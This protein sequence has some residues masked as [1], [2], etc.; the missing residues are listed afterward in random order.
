M[1]VT[2]VIL[3]LLWG[4]VYLLMAEGLNLI[5]GVMK[6]VNLAHGDFIVLGGLI[7]FSLF[8]ATAVSPVIS[9]PIAALLLAALGAAVQFGVVERI[10]LGRPDAE[11]RTLLATFGLSYVVAN[12]SFLIWGSQFQSIPFLQGF[13]QMGKIAL[14]QALLA[15]SAL[16]FVFAVLFHLWLTR[17]MLGKSIRAVA[18]SG[19]GAAACGLDIVSLR[20]LAF[21]LGSAMAGGAG[22]L[23]IAL[24]PFQTASGGDL[25]RAGLHADRARR[26]RQLC[27][28]L[29]RRR[30]PGP[31]RGRDPICLRLQCGER[32]D[33]CRLHRRAGAAPA[34]PA[35]Q[36][37]ARMKQRNVEIV[38]FL[39]LLAAGACVAA[40]G[41]GYQA[42]TLF[43]MLMMT[44]LAIGWNIISGFTGYVSFGQVAFFGLGAYVTAVLILQGDLPWPLA[45]AISVVG[46]VI[47][48]LPLGLVMLRLS[49]IF[50][51]LGMFGL[52]R[53]FQL[54]ASSLDITGGPMG[55]T[56]PAAE[57]PNFLAAVALGVV[58]L[59][60]TLSFILLR[61]KLGLRL[62]ATRDDPV[63]AQAAGVD[64]WA[65]KV[66]AFCLSAAIA[67]IAGALYVWNVGYLDPSS[68]FAGTIE[69][70]TVLMVLAGGIGT[71]WGPVLGGVLI[72]LLSTFLWARFP[73]EQQIILGLLTML[74]AMFAPGGLM[75]LVMQRG[76]FRRQ[77]IWPPMP[78]QGAI[79]SGARRDAAPVKAIEPVLSGAKV[80]IHY[81]G[82]KAVD[83][84][85]VQ[86]K[87]GEMLAIIGPNGAGKSSLFNL[88]SGFGRPTHGDVRFGG[89]S[90]IGAAPYRLARNGV[91]RTFQTSRLFRSL[92]VW[93][94]VLVA[95]TSVAVDRAS[96]VAATMLIL[97]RVGLLRNWKDLPD[98][99]PPGRQ[100]L[101]EIA[102]SLALAPKVLLLD[103]A[104][105]G[106]TPQEIEQV[107]VT[108][109]AALAAGVAIIAIEHV[110]PAIAPL[111]ARV[112]VLDFGRTIAEGEPRSVLRDP[113]V[114]EAYMGL[115]H[116]A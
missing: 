95:A 57:S 39:L 113:V 14:P 85:D 36:V 33:L 114:V 74:V 107:H 47:V 102:R 101:L 12:A 52:A 92:T 19:L 40:F 65:A 98:L 21:A 59:A 41:T 49:G 50:F 77:P 84:V 55:T 53:I 13:V 67:A 81:G 32:G 72:S 66:V 24:I 18:Q 112:Q 63:A 38:L 60:A 88:L 80:S 27:G 31:R 104:M 35:R 73:M 37:G 86:A 11:L 70:Q 15:C 5:Y 61:T 94:T 62:L 46:A 43:Q 29:P 17:S 34:R 48:A 108:L 87:A 105:A 90:I 3:G 9:F 56:V 106:M 7:A 68:A 44:L 103:E 16:A 20:V 64:I 91:A 26:A 2:L 93:E 78:A 83:R 96:A 54:T 79:A 110:L 100:R 69:L 6:V 71:V 45:M 30:A 4:G 116:A 82:V 89:H 109:R 28:R 99:L 25:N 76:W 23:L 58:A 22:A 97:D 51:A 1:I 115:D 75:G 42:Q 10:G 8:E 111:A